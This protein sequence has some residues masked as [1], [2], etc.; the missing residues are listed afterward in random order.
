MLACGTKAEIVLCSLALPGLLHARG[1]S[2]RSSRLA[3]CATLPLLGVLATLAISHALAPELDRASSFARS[4]TATLP[5]T[6]TNFLRWDQVS[7]NG[8]VLGWPMAIRSRTGF[9]DGLAGSRAP[10]TG[11]DEGPQESWEGEG[12][13]VADGGVA[14][15]IA[16]SSALS[17]R[18]S[19]DCMGRLVKILMRFSISP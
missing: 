5:N 19:S 3:G 17:A 8:R 7:I 13:A 2:L 11:R 15:P 1:V 10:A 9:G 12:G 6:L 14:F 4:W 16:S 18:R